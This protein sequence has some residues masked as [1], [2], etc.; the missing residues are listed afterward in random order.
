VEVYRTNLG[1]LYL[2]DC[3]EILPQIEDTVDLVL[4]DPP[5]NVSR[6]VVIHRSMSP[7]KY[8]YTGKDINLDFG[9]WDHFESEK[10]YLEFTLRW[11]DEA[12]RLLKPSGHLISFFDQNL[13]TELIRIGESLGL[14]MRQHLYWLKC[15]GGD[16]VVL[17]K[18]DGWVKRETLEELYR[19]WEKVQILTPSGF[20]PI[21]AMMRRYSLFHYKIET[22]VCSMRISGNH[23]LPYWIYPNYIQWDKPFEHFLSLKSPRLLTWWGGFDNPRIK[24]ING[25][26]LTWEWGWLVGLFVAEGNYSK[27]TQVRFSLHVKERDIVR[28][29]KQI[30]EALSFYNSKMQPKGVKVYTFTRGNSV[31]VYFGS[32][33]IRNFISSFVKGG[34]A[35]TKRL[36]IDLLF[37][38]P[39]EFRQG[40]WEGIMEGDG[41]RDPK[42]R[43]RMLTL[44]NKGLIEDITWLLFSLGIPSRYWQGWGA[45]GRG[46][47]FDHY[48]LKTTF[49][50]PC[51]H[52]KLQGFRPVRRTDL[53]V[54][55]VNLIIPL[56]DLQVEGEVFICGRGLVSHNSNPVPRARKVDFMVALEHAC[57]F[58]K[59]PRKGATFNY[60]LGQQRNYVEA[61]IPSGR[62]RIHPTQ[63]PLKV[64]E[65]WISYL[66][67]PGDL[68]LDPFAGSGSTAVAC[69]KLGRRWIAIEKEGEYFEKAVEWLES[70]TAQ[71]DLF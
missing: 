1:R 49:G 53:K 65:T 19:N 59:P 64:L 48:I 21:K 66:T 5:W 27:T 28:R 44:A 40:L 15:L 20:R 18:R 45:D 38:C 43:Y 61:P 69:E 17:I 9:E 8:K 57:W 32:R 41:N 35:K 25:F 46:K 14:Q 56:Y 12:T 16:T 62:W 37:N 42:A 7:K 50:K 70:I 71:L 33:R 54:E 67:N 11:M 31:V 47:V 24:E 52:P 13:T 39:K 3:L 4:T 30:V 34:R 22:P 23:A 63:K 26:P 36:N 60:Q 2:G 58:T 55:R 29:I 10:E 6:E 51:K 68:V